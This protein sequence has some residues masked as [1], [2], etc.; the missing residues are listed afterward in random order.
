MF[1]NICKKVKVRFTVNFLCFLS[2]AL[3]I[4]NYWIAAENWNHVNRTENKSLLSSRKSCRQNRPCDNYYFF[5]DRYSQQPE[6]IVKRM[7]TDCIQK[8]YPPIFQSIRSQHASAT[9]TK[10]I[11][12]QIHIP[13]FPPGTS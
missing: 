11:T 2:S 10:Q 4:K 12:P 5:P 13:V 1:R 8:A 7:P 9:V 6:A 3:Y